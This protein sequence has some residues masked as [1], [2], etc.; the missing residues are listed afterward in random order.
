MVGYTLLSGFYVE[1]A[2][3]LAGML[4]Q[5]V[6]G[7][8]IYPHSADV[9][10][11]ALLQPIKFYIRKRRHIVYNTIRGRDVLKEC[12]GAERRRGTPPRLF[13]A[14]QDMSMPE[15]LV[16][17]AEGGEAHL[18]RRHL[19]RAW[20]CRR[21]P[22]HIAEERPCEA[23]SV[24]DATTEARWGPVHIND[25]V[26]GWARVGCQSASAISSLREYTS[27]TPGAW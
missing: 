16:Y 12:E 2:R 7:V 13:W 4:P 19:T 27:E 6:K 22:L 18:P 26:V 24:T 21:G 5:K 3:R 25:Y 14:E 1:A 10:A 15:R 9:L 20:P 23:M 17:G 11:V 8:W